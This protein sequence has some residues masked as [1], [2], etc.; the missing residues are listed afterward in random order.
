ME[1]EGHDTD[2]LIDL[3][4][5]DLPEH[6]VLTRKKF[7]PWHHPRKHWVRI[8]QLCKYSQILFNESYFQDNTIKY[9]TLPGEELMDVQTIIAKIGSEELLDIQALEGA[10]EGSKKRGLLLKYIGFN[11]IGDNKEKRATLEYA[12]STIKDSS[13]VH[14]ESRVINDQVQNIANKD[15]DSYDYVKNNGPYNIINLDLC[16]S[17]ANLPPDSKTHTYFDA[18]GQIL[19]IQRS[20]MSEPFMMFIATKTTHDELDPKSLE[21]ITKVCGENIRRSPDFK[22]KFEQIVEKEAEQLL[23]KMSKGESISQEVLNKVFGVGLG[24]WLLHLV[25]PSAPHWDVS[26]EDICC[27]SIGDFE[28]NMLSLAFKFTKVN[29]NISDDYGLFNIQEVNDGH[30]KSESELAI[31]MLN[32]SRTILD[33]DDLLKKDKEKRDK[34]IKQA[35][36]LLN[37]S[38]YSERDY[39]DWAESLFTDSTQ[40]AIA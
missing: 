21:I 30:I 15:S 3:I 5:D 4:Y 10:F 35:G 29:E 19:E 24:K 33:I 20:H 37:K 38:G 34:I 9:L 11:N 18:I 17:V 14:R 22:N 27:Y 23:I 32:R 7:K 1:D 2:D 16:N 13:I 12:E 40:A 31:D 28:P 39:S 25:K 6:S 36:R 8:N 26:L